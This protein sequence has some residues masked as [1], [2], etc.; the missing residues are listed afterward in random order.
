MFCVGSVLGGD[1]RGGNLRLRTLLVRLILRV[2]TMLSARFM[3]DAN[4]L[5]RTYRFSNFRRFNGGITTT[6]YYFLRLFR[7]LFQFIFIAILRTTR[8]TS[9][10][11][12]FFLHYPYGLRIVRFVL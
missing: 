1:T 11:F 7:H 4:S 9:L 6:S 12:F 2:P 3:W 8:V 10:Y 5:T